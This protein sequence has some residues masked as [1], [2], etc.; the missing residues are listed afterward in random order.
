MTVELPAGMNAAVT[1]NVNIAITGIDKEQVGNFTA[2]LRRISP[3]EPYGGK[4]IRYFDEVIK[5]KEGK[6]SHTGCCPSE[7]RMAQ[8]A[9][10]LLRSEVLYHS[11]PSLVLLPWNAGWWQEEVNWGPAVTFFF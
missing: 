6:A 9:R 4:G 8:M 1:Q 2:N 5:L 10:L 3:P 7:G 11:S